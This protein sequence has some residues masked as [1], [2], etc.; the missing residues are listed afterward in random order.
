LSWSE[1][2]LARSYLYVP[3][4][5]RELVDK[6]LASAADAVVVDLED[7]VAES[8]RPRARALVR[9]LLAGAP[10][11]PVWV[12]ISAPRGERARADVRAAASPHLA[13]LRVPKVQGAA[14]LRE[15]AGWLEAEG[16]RAPLCAL[17]ESAAGLEAIAQIAVAHPA[18]RAVALGEADLGADLGTSSDRGLLYARSRCVAAA[19]AAGLPPPVQSVYAALGD[20]Q[21]LRRSTELGRELGFFGRSA[22]HPS[23]LATINEVYTP[24]RQALEQARE[25]IRSLDRSLARDQA[26]F[27]LQ[28]GSF[29]DRA[30]VQRARRTVALAERLGMGA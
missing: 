15:V 4:H 8:E 13:G 29:V 17:I 1:P 24:S 21:G 9:E 25:L 19:R 18:L 3:G 28:D 7:A 12:R 14:E 2:P 6:A 11:R 16:C 26:A 5:R 10:P 30:V 27:V 20:E 22:I 23:Q